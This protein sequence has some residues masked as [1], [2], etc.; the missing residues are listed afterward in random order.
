MDIR[1]SYYLDGAKNA[2]GLAVI[3][4]VFRAFSTA[5]YI[6]GSG[7]GRIILAANPEQALALKNDHPGCVLI[8][9]KNARIVNGFDYGNSPSSV[10]K[11]DLTGKTAVLMT[12]AGTRG[13]LGA[14]KADEVLTGSFVNAG[15]IAEYILRKKP[16][17]VSL[18]CMGWNA[19]QPAD[20]DDM[21]AEFIKSLIE[22]APANFKK[23]FDFLKFKSATKSFL[24]LKDE[25]SAPT[26]DFDLCLSLD[27]FGFVLKAERGGLRKVYPSKI[28][29]AC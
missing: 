17:K 29:A 10:E 22:G 20:E 2:E 28:S 9:E 11:A 26:E 13:V 18:V 24:G 7:A 15:S 14:E 19:N 5:C 21:C 6:Y 23:I 3:I 25:K 4:D 12:S 8:G 16:R 1:K 27:K